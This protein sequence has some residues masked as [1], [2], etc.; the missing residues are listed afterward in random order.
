MELITHA[1]KNIYKQ[2]DERF[3]TFLNSLLPRSDTWKEIISNCYKFHVTKFGVIFMYK[4]ET[5]FLWNDGTNAVD[6][7][8][9]YEYIN[10]NVNDEKY[11]PSSKSDIDN[12]LYIVY[13][14]RKLKSIDLSTFIQIKN[15]QV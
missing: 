6:S 4:N 12:V 8:E 15:K 13:V 7:F 9:L 10:I 3:I 1:K 14:I 11:N 2:K 5:V